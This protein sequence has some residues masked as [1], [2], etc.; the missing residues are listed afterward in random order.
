MVKKL[1]SK[2]TANSTL[3]PVPTCGF[4]LL[5]FPLAVLML[6]VGTVSGYAQ[7]ADE[8]T[9]TTADGT[10]VRGDLVEIGASGV[11]LDRGSEISVFPVDDLSQIRFDR[12]SARSLPMQTQLAGGSSLR[13]SAISL[14]DQSVSISVG[15]Q[16][17]LVVPIKQLHW[18]RFRMG[19]PATDPAWLGWLEETRRAD[20]LVVRRNEKTLDSIDGTVVGITRD[21]VQF[22]M[23]GNRIDAPLAKLEG[24]LLS[25]PTDVPPSSALR[26]TDTSGSVWSVVSLSLPRGSSSVRVTLSGGIEHEIPLNQVTDIRFA[27]GVLTLA[28][29]EIAES[30]FGSNTANP[31]ITKLRELD[32]W[33]APQTG[34]GVISI[35]AP[36]K[37]TLRIP[38]G[39]Q[40]LIVAARRAQDVNQFTAIGLEVLLDGDIKWTGTL[41]DRQ[42]LGLELPLADA[43]Q[44]TLRATTLPKTTATN[45]N[46]QAE[47]G[48]RVEWFSGRLL[49]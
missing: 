36:G 20:R 7:S 27:G 3:R 43:R 46:V 32:K 28:D 14:T 29:A 16:S 37:I 15:R 47:L 35:N 4:A 10:I 39:Y 18:V 17:P 8:V 44:L 9:I 31:A 1:A 24:V 45:E 34:D 49:K 38:E 25:T 11:H 2:T 40:R 23:R 21:S 26:L 42:S 22:E 48:G 41:Q 30:S 6:L 13:V 12:E 33:F 5:T 19:N